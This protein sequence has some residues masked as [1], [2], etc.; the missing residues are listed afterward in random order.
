MIQRIFKSIVLFT[1]FS[2]ISILPQDFSDGIKLMK[3]EKYN[4]A[5]KYFSTLLN[6]PQN[7]DVY[8]YLGQ[9]YFNEGEYDS[10]KIN[11]MNG[12]NQNN[13]SALNYAGLVKVNI[14]QNNSTEAEKNKI[15]ALE[16]N[17]DKSALVYLVLSQAY[18]NSEV[19]QYKTAVELL[20]SAIKTDPN[21]V[22]AYIELGN[23]YLNQGDGSNAIKNFDKALELQNGNPEALIYKAGVYGL[24]NDTDDA[25]KFLNQ[26]ISSDS[27]FAPAYKNLAE[28]YATLKDYVKASENY[29]KYINNS[30]ATPENLKRYASMLYIN[31]D[32]EKAIK[33]LEDNYDSEKGAV[34]TDRILAYSYQRLD[35]QQ[36]SKY[37]F[38][39]LFSLSSANYLPTDYEYYADLLSKNAQ[40]SLAI[41]YLSQ[42]VSTDSTRKDIWGKISVLCFK[43]RDW[44][45]VINALENKK[46]LTTQEYFDL[47]KAY[48]FLGDE[49]INNGLQSL[50]DQLGLTTEQLAELRTDLL[51]YQKD[52]CDAGINSQKKHD[53]L[54]KLIEKVES[55]IAPNQKSKWATVKQDWIKETGNKT[56]NE[57]AE[58]DTAFIMVI[59]KVPNL[60]I[61]YL[62]KARVSADFDPEST[63]G[64][65]KP[66]YEQFIQI[67]AKEA[68]KFKKELVEAYAYLGY[69]YYLQKDNAQSKV[70]W[71]QVLLLDPENKQANDVLKQLK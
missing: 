19:K 24:I 70:Y 49:K 21:Y 5:K 3:L 37:Y 53:A 18:S 51:Y 13:Q 56:S 36:K 54:N 50:N 59:N 12:I 1:I 55:F 26:A 8:F 23:A 47:G 63:A 32:Y 33:I 45:G 10:A 43:V 15:K 38:E 34:S 42:I 7:S 9:I 41:K 6:T 28:V 20:N 46:S 69:Y 67:A 64:L 35:N 25:I 71:Q 65:A 39:K 22:D 31:K 61:G 52:L 57:Y 68:E 27:T 16:L 29:A 48:M 60:P 17:D 62:W 11:F 30:E 14:A 44:N 66:M 2:R 58:A 4:A 40:D